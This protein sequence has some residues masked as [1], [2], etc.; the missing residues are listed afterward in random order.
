MGSHPEATLVYG[1]NLGDGVS[2]DDINNLGIVGLSNSK[3]SALRGFAEEHGLD[4]TYSWGWSDGGLL[5]TSKKTKSFCACE[6]PEKIPEVLPPVDPED[7]KTLIDIAKKLN[8]D[9][10]GWYLVPFYG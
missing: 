7:K 1:V 9:E 4:L 10:P 3:V 8:L 2:E 5:L 6:D